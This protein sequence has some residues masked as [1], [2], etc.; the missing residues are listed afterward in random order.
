M[1]TAISAL[2]INLFALSLLGLKVKAEEIPTSVT[3]LAALLLQNESASST[4]ADLIFG[5]NLLQAIQTTKKN[6]QQQVDNQLANPAYRA[7]IVYSRS[8]PVE[9]IVSLWNQDTNEFDLVRVMKKGSQLTLINNS[10]YKFKLVGDNGVNSL[11]E[12]SNRPDLRVIGLIYPVFADISTAKLTRYRL[13][14]VVYI[15]YSDKLNNE[16][17]VQTGEDYLNKKIQAVYDELNKLGIKS[18]ADPGKLITEVIDPAVVKT[19]IAIEHVD[20]S[21]LLNNSADQYLHRFYATL[22]TNEHA[23]YAYAKSSAS[24]RGLVQFIPSTYANLRKIRPE[25]TL[26]ADF[27]QGMTDPYNA[28]KAQI[29]LLDYNLTLLPSEIK[30][31]DTINPENLGAYSAAMYN[32][33]PTRVRRAISQW[34]EAW[35]SY[36]GNLASSLRLETAYY[37]AKFRLVFKHF[38]GQSLHLAGLVPVAD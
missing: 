31:Q 19:I 17:I 10:N 2:L 3:P 4:A 38:D 9:I 22:A 25:L 24:A 18:K 1:K 21:V 16:V 6:L 7:P 15:P 5:Q 29:G 13:E 8:A 33:G 11:I 36:H 27:V 12:I 20:A 30:K 23:S 35:D 34:G 32:G 28:I 26:H 37:V 14:N